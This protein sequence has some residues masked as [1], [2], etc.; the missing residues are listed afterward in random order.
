MQQLQDGI[1]A[2]VS[3]LKESLVWTSLVAMGVH[4]QARFVQA[5]HWLAHASQ[6]DLLQCEDSVLPGYAFGYLGGMTPPR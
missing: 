1:N 6:H 5:L 3:L 2:V 4:M